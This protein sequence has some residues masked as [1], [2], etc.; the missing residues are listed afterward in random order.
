MSSLRL[1]SYGLAGRCQQKNSVSVQVSG[2]KTSAIGR[3]SVKFLVSGQ[4]GQTK[5]YKMQM[6]K[7]ADETLFYRKSFAY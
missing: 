4:V 3:F 6:T 2:F 1:E 7:K 5:E